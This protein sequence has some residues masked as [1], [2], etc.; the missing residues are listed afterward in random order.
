MPPLIKEKEP[1]Q[2]TVGGVFVKKSAFTLFTRL[3]LILSALGASIVTARILGPA[4]KGELAIILLAPNL[5][6]NLGGIAIT[7]ANVFLIG[8]K[9]WK[10][11]EIFW[12]SIVFAFIL[13]GILIAAFF[14]F[15]P[16]IHTLFKNADELLLRI[17]VFSIPLSLLYEFG[18]FIPLGQ[19]KVI[20]YNCLKTVEPIFYL[21]ALLLLVWWFRFG[22]VGGVAAYIAGLAVGYIVFLIFAIKSLPL[23]FGMNFALGKQA[24]VYALKCHLGNATW[25][26]TRRI[27]VLLVNRFLLPADV[28]YYVIA[29]TVSE[30]LWHLPQTI[31][32]VLFPEICSKDDDLDHKSM[33]S[34]VCRNTIFILVVVAVIFGVATKVLVHAF[35]GTAYLPSVKAIWILLPGS[36]LLGIYNILSTYMRGIGRPMLPSLIACVMLVLTVILSV[37]LIPVGGIY[38]AALAMTVTYG[39]GFAI[40]V[41]VYQKLTRDRVVDF[42][43]LSRKDLVY[44]RHFAREFRARRNRAA[45]PC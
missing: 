30:A 34:R 6:I 3:A 4:K 29:I 15:Y 7:S 13:G 22:V 18:I 24:T 27:A 41:V 35:Y 28:G 31:S 14:I 1:T 33:C 8:S 11:N 43:I 10:L 37:I 21:L 44:Y 25:F 16:W 19:R 38:G 12:N 32:T 17:A 39:I 20:L 42:L 2:G 36:V 45:R 9:K 26:L 23:D 40:I 5:L